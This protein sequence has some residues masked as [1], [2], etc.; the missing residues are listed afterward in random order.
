M[1]ISMGDPMSFPSEVQGQLN[2]I[3]AR[4]SKRRTASFAMLFECNICGNEW[5]RFIEQATTKCYSFLL[6]C[7]GPFQ[8]EPQPIIKAVGDGFHASGANASFQPDNG[9]IRLC[10]DYVMGRPGTTLEKVCHELTHASL[11][12]FPEG[13]PFYEEGVVDYSVWCIAHAPYWGEHRQ[14]MIEAAAHNIAVRRDRAMKDLNDYDR[15]RWAGG[16]FC[17]AMHGPWILSKLR[18]RKAEGDLRW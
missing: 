15:K 13:D 9:Q 12:D 1:S 17:H 18:M 10:P 16:M 3:S 7:L 6:D 5:D 11:N 2:D 4:L 14:A 8:R